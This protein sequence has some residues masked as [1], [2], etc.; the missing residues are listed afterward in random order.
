MTFGGVIFL[1]GGFGTAG[2]LRLLNRF[3][4][5]FKMFQTV[6][7]N[8]WEISGEGCN[9]TKKSRERVENSSGL[10]FLKNKD[11]IGS[12]VLLYMVTFTNTP[13]VSIYTSTMDPSW[14]L[15][16]QEKQ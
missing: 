8:E 1:V 6:Q 7:E 15:F 3:I 10:Q 5:G 16:F 13:N 9:C 2:S 12:M 11:P 4:G 14:D